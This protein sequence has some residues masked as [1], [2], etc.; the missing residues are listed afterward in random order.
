MSL[1]CHNPDFDPATE[2]HQM[3]LTLRIDSNDLISEKD[4]KYNTKCMQYLSEKIQ[5]DLVD[6]PIDIF[7]TVVSLAEGE[8]E[9]SCHDIYVSFLL[10]GL[11]G[12]LNF[13][14]DYKIN[15]NQFKNDLLC[16]QRTNGE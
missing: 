12:W 2:S 14:I 11:N 4:H 8:G 15:C 5:K 13:Q 3:A 9:N 16:Y 6:K 7:L 10:K 1:A